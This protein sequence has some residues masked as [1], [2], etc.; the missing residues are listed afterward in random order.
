MPAGPYRVRPICSPLFVRA[1]LSA[2]EETYSKPLGRLRA[3]RAKSPASRN[4]LFALALDRAIKERGLSLLGL[5]MS[6]GWR[7]GSID[8]IPASYFSAR[9]EG[10]YTEPNQTV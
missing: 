4:S 3:L 2:G 6:T 9:G 10:S 5:P 7:S 8:R 1:R